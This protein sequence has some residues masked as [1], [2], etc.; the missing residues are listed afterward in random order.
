MGGFYQ[1]AFDQLNNSANDHANL[2]FT[3]NCKTETDNLVRLARTPF[4][5]S[6]QP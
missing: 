1:K 6:F 2:F 5:P 4:L 3:N